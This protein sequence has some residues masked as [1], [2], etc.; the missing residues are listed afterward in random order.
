[1]YRSVS[2]ARCGFVTE[3]KIV[4]AILMPINMGCDRSIGAGKGKAAK[5]RWQASPVSA[6]KE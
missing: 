3:F 1:M 5:A 4:Q 2:T 6:E